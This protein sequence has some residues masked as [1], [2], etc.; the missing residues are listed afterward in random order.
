MKVSLE[1]PDTA[2]ASLREA[3]EH[4]AMA[5]RVAA[6]VTWYELGRLSQAWAAELAGLSRAAFIEA[7]REHQVP[8]VQVES[9]RR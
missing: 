1:F 9:P 2:P 3:P 4:L 8:A 7:L 6:C 5:L